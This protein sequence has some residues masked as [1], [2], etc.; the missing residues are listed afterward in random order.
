MSLHWS[1]AF[2]TAILLTGTLYLNGRRIR[3]GWL[4]GGLVQLVNVGFGLAYGQATFLF[5][6]LPTAMFAWN[7]W[8]HPD[9]PRRK[10]RPQDPLPPSQ[11]S[12]RQAVKRTLPGG[13]LV[14][15]VEG[16]RCSLLAGHEDYHVAVWWQDGAEEPLHASWPDYRSHEYREAQR[17]LAEVELVKTITERSH[18]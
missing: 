13:Q 11:C 8:T 4:L 12:S 6:L 2:V 17:R 9:N 14:E 16:R 1:W 10:H 3:V 15:W 18:P 7:W 5:L